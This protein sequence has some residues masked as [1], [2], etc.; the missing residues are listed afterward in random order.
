MAVCL[1]LAG[2]LLA[3]PAERDEEQREQIDEQQ[4][5]EKNAPVPRAALLL[6]RGERDL[7][8]RLAFP[9]FVEIA[10]GF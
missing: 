4:Q 3:G 6:Y 1:P 8:E 5:L 7:L 2:F 10:F 9:V